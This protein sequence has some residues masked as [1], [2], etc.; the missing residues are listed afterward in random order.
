MDSGV[1]INAGT[2][3]GV[4]IGGVYRLSSDQSHVTTGWL[5]S[6]VTIGSNTEHQ[7]LRYNLGLTGTSIA[8]SGGLIDFIYAMTGGR[9]K[10][11]PTLNTMTFYRA[12]NVTVVATFNL[13]DSVAAATY[14]NVY[15]RTRA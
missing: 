7:Q 13:L 12:D 3:A 15:E 4:T 11:D 10:I 2:Y 6:G 9:W 14:Q 8:S 5:A 1:T